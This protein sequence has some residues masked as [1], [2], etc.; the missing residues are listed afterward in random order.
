MNKKLSDGMVPNMQ[1][2]L[3]REHWQDLLSE[4]ILRRDSLDKPLRSI[5]TPI[6]PIRDEIFSP[7][8][9]EAEADTQYSDYNSVDQITRLLL[10]KQ[11]DVCFEHNEGVV[12]EDRCR[13]SHGHENV[14]KQ[15]SRRQ[16]P[17]VMAGQGQIRRGSIIR[18][19]R[20][21]PT[22]KIER[23]YLDQFLP[24]IHAIAKLKRRLAQANGLNE[25]HIKLLEQK[26]IGVIY[27]DT[28][29]A[30]HQTSKKA[31]SLLEKNDG[32]S[33][34]AGRLGGQSH[35]NTQ[36]IHN[37][38]KL[39]ANDKKLEYLFIAKADTNEYYRLSVHPVASD[40]LSLNETPQL[41]VILLA[42]TEDIIGIDAT[43]FQHQYKLTKSEIN[44][45]LA[46]LNSTS[47]D[48]YARQTSI[49]KNTVRWTL[50]NIFSKTEANS[51]ARLVSLMHKF[52]L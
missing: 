5:D 7:V 48:A 12:R 33:N 39:A 38:V 18:S 8:H 41:F 20:Q 1:K 47:L 14:D 37:L 51:Q 35:C 30:I 26:N 31:D 16:R 10:E 44:L 34:Q 32:V 25:T 11:Y 24:F 45:S 40:D 17:Y 19:K 36:R 3:D 13:A 46:L 50:G 43:A 23:A 27:V 2:V 6:T 21:L 15:G 29:L 9:G 42:E 49:S 22:S 4:V 28:N 52:Q